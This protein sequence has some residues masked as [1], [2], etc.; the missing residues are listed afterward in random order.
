MAVMQAVMVLNDIRLDVDPFEEA[1]QLARLARDA[2]HHVLVGAECG[3]LDQ[4]SSIMAVL[5]YLVKIEYTGDDERPVEIEIVP[6]PD[7]LDLVFVTF[8]NPN[9]TRTLEKSPYNE[10]KD[11]CEL[12]LKILR[13]IFQPDLAGLGALKPNEFQAILRDFIER[14]AQRPEVFAAE[15]QPQFIHKMIARV[16]HVIGEV[17]RVREVIALLN[18]REM[19]IEQKRERILQITNA[20]GES[21]VELHGVAAGVPELPVLL[22]AIRIFNKQIAARNHG[23]G[24]NES[25]VLLMRRDIADRFE[26]EFVQFLQ[27]GLL[28]AQIDAVL[29][30]CHDRYGKEAFERAQVEEILNEFKAAKWKANIVYPGRGSNVLWRQAIA[31]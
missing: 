27:E 12:G 29:E 23:G 3:F 4:F 15:N 30:M 1:Y 28:P 17:Q 2:E 22:S 20:C 7:E 14:A 26:K 24:F 8:S 10:M 16:N 21:S 25:T 19:D 6:F 11:M 13:E 5:G 18:D 31:A 9:F